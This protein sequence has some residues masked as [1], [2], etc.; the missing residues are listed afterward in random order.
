MRRKAFVPSAALALL[1]AGTAFAAFAPVVPSIPNRPS[2]LLETS[3]YVYG[4]GL[5]FTDV[6]L[7]LSISNRRDYN[8]PVTLYLY[9]ED[10]DSG[11]RG[12]YNVQEGNFIGAVLDLFGSAGSPVSLIAPNLSNFR[13]FGEDGALGPVPDS[14]ST[15]TGHYQFVFE[16]RDAQ[17]ARVISRA[18]A[19]YNHVDGVVQV[20]GAL[21][22]DA[23]W[24]SNN[25]YYLATPVNVGTES[26]TT[27]T[28]EPGTVILGSNAGQG[29]LIIRP[30]SQIIADGTDTHPIVF[31]SEQP[32]GVRATGDWGG[33]V[34]SGRAPTNQVNPVGEGDSGPYG[35]LQPNDSSGILRYVRV[36]FAGIR[37]SEQNELNGIAFQGVG[38][39]T[40]VDH[41]QVHFNQDDGAEFFGGTVNV[42]YLLLTDAQDDSLDW[43]FGWTGSIQ[44]LVAI[45]RTSSHDLGIEADNSETNFLAQPTSRP[46]IYNATWVGN[47]PIA[48]ADPTADTGGGWLLRRGTL[49]LISHAIVTNFWEQGVQVDGEPGLAAFGGALDVRNS[50]FFRN[51]MGGA[52]EFPPQAA[53]QGV[54]NRPANNNSTA[55]PLLPNPNHIVQPDVAP[56]RES[57]ARNVGATAPNDGFFDQVPWAGGVNPE[58]PWID[59]GWTTFS[60]N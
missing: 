51:E 60:D 58:D 26:S 48:A 41:I 49:G 43:T 16:V 47:G 53:L 19:M 32:V 4:P 14:I 35:G 28:I 5:D 36:E 59:D 25:V 40:V 21:N 20:S 13:L 42:K 3:Y 50:F 12:Y 10:R 27:L 33:L 34:I 52:D 7:S 57:P 56:L 24:T 17:G 39:G 29:V 15:D 18:N 22:A 11:E 6:E 55:N 44:H 37:F 31:S 23:T 9:W 45:Q 46:T 54:L 1:T 38:R 30:G 8:D 2:T